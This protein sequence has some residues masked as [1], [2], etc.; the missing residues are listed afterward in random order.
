MTSELFYKK[1][2]LFIGFTWPEPTST[3]AGNR[4]LQLLYFFLEQ[5]YRTIFASAAAETPLSLNL[6]AMGI[7]KASI[8]LNDASF[9]EFVMGLNPDIVI[10]D[11]FLTEEQFGW[12]VAESV[13]DALRILDTEDLHSLRNTRQTLF[14]RDIPFSID[15]WLQNDTTKRE[16]ASIYRTDLSLIISS[17]EMQLLT[18]T[19]KIDKNLL[20]HL[21]FMLKALD[22]QT[23]KKW[24]SFDARKDFVCIGNGKHAPN[25]DAI[26]WLKNEIWPL[27]RNKLPDAELHIYGAYLP[28]HIQHL[29]NLKEGFRIMGWSENAETVL[30]EAKVSL[31]P[32]RFGAGIKGKLTDAMRAGTPTVTTSIGAEGMHTGLNW[33]GQ[34]AETAEDLAR[35]AV[36]LY[37]NHEKWRSAQLN[38]ITII[39]GLYD[40]RVLHQNLAGKIANLGNRLEEH[41]TQNFI[42]AMLRH[43]TLASTKFMSKWIEEKNRS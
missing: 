39:N 21:P 17:Y 23:V 40:K 9:D 41:R 2:V 1:T 30:R 24:P 15:A 28:E 27:I 11:R 37:Q 3:A 6:E 14:K 4:M 5:K 20:L 42:G 8:Q 38:G 7:E 36:S 13:P 12:R 33:N 25:I 43:Q 19:L 32:L 26:Q 35:A 10:F 29:N 34:I 16:I 22:E 18:D 31:A